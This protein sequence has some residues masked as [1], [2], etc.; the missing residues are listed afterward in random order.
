LLKKL[1]LPMLFFA[2]TLM[3]SACNAANSKSQTAA[4]SENVRT[5]LFAGHENDAVRFS[6]IYSVSGENPF[7]IASFGEVTAQL[8][9]GTG[10]IAFG[11]PDCPRC[12]NAFPV[13]EKAFAKKN[14]GRHAGFRGKILYYDFYDDREANNERY[15]AIVDYIKDF[16]PTED[17][18][19]P[20][21]YSPDI[22]FIASGKIVGNHLDTVPGLTDPHDPLNDQQEAELLKMYMD[23]IEK[24]EDCGC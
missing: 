14:M 17:N 5:D 13:L 16:L 3:F 24:V 21:L 19:N 22:F 9:W 12:R 18:G 4:S 23:L 8:K 10:I 7:I 1:L 11:F 20:R 2:F 15:R 6:E